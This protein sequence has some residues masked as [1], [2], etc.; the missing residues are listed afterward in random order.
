[1]AYYVDS[2]PELV[3]SE[4]RIQLLTVIIDTLKEILDNLR[5][6]HTVIKNMIDH[7]KYEAG[8]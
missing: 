4:A 5:W 6:R 2:D 8:F 7:R 3:A 1:M